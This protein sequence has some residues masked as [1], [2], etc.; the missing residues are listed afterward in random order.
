[1]QTK[2]PDRTF[3]RVLLEPKVRVLT[4]VL[5]GIVTLSSSLA[6]APP[7][8]TQGPWR[9]GV[10]R[11]TAVFT[12]V[13]DGP[14]TSQIK[15][16]IDS[17]TLNNVQADAGI[18]TT[19]HSW[20]ASGLPGGTQIYYQVCSANTAG[21]T[22][23]TVDSFSTPLQTAIPAA[24]A[25]PKPVDSPVIPTG[26]ILTVGA[27][28]DDP[29][30]GLV[31]MWNRA[32]WGD[33]VEIDPAVTPV[34]AG[35]YVFPAK[36]PDTAPNRYIL[37]RVRNAAGLGQGRVS[38]LNRLRM[39]RFIDTAPNVI[40]I[41]SADPANLSCFAGSYLWRQRQAN[42]WAM[43]RCNNQPPQNITQIP[44][45][46][47]LNVTVPNHGIQDGRMVWVSNATGAGAA[48]VNGSWLTQV[49]DPNTILLKAYIGAAPQT[50]TGPA[51]G[52]TMSLNQ[53]Q[54]E[55]VIEGSDLPAACD[56][57]QWWHK[58]A[59]SGSEDEYHRTYYCSADNQWLPYRMDPNSGAT[60][61]PVIDLVTNQAHN[62]IFQGLSFEP[63]PLK[64]DMQRL[65]YTYQPANQESGTLFWSF[66]SQSRKNHHIYWDQILADCP[67]P[68]PNGSMVRCH[69]F[70]NP[71]DGAHI[72]VRRSYFRG[73]QI[74][75][76]A[77][78]LD[79]GSAIVFSVQHGP[80]PHEFV[81]NHIECTGICVYY[82]DDTASTSDASDLTFTQNDVAT[83]DRYWDRSP[84]WL[85]K[86]SFTQ[87]IF[88]SQRHRFEL[89]RLKRGIL[90]GNTFTGG[91]AWINNAAAICLC[92]RG[93]ASG[94]QISS[95][96]DST[97]VTYDAS[98]LYDWGIEDLHVGD[99]VVLQN[100][101]GGTCASTPQVF[102]VASVVNS[103]TFTVS[104]PPGCT[105][106]RGNVA[107][108]G[109]ET[110]YI[111]DIAI[112]NNTIKDS[113][114]GVY[115]LGHDSYAGPPNGLISDAMQRVRIVNNLA[116]RLDGTRVGM[117]QFSA[118]PEVA[119]TGTFVVPIYAMED[120]EVSHN[121][122]YPRTT[123]AFMNSDSGV[124]GP[125]SGLTLKANI[126]EYLAGSGLVNDGSFF[127]VT[128][129][130]KAW[131]SGTLP[132]FTAPYN[133]ILR[134]GGAVGSPADPT[135][136]PFGPYPASTYWLDTNRT[137]VPF[138]N[139][140]SGDYSLT[141][142]YRHADACNG[143]PGDCTDDGTDVGVNMTTLLAAQPKP[144][145]LLH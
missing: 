45:N 59:S 145:T 111:S 11:S 123:G 131:L 53:F 16:G 19:I 136:P 94:S 142:L 43:Y 91:W 100:L 75:H 87:N 124:G 105:A 95:V 82:T 83:P 97:I 5:V 134:P 49:V 74:F 2:S 118:H 9:T 85:G 103:F 112:T 40:M 8:I 12:W 102:S 121:T 52:G 68:D 58:Q 50:S 140:A 80:G 88:W 65:Q 107:R 15:W 36:A 41:G 69:A 10:T 73:W 139:P 109:N 84:E 132:Q 104:P 108:L 115:M 86:T 32:N 17:S 21:A 98:T 7:N 6:A 54:L 44:D 57:G 61:A 127:G 130:T 76:S 72:S 114:T 56:Y 60:P 64:A 1:M 138:K 55:P 37:T 117:G 3:V 22:C 46:G 28:C 110:A 92:T 128:G 71:L 62:L 4:I 99:R 81:N 30:T 38:S 135:Q 13:T 79:D 122:V 51:S 141:G 34:C 18:P 120:L 77:Q 27:N 14:S 89:K 66:V 129:L 39:A 63:L 24:P 78:D 101:A 90:D 137:P 20:Y 35:S 23:S 106:T 47:P 26:N 29:A 96:S 113:P 48:A 126:F 125:S 42:A 25:P 67:D 93:G 70:A 33:I 31:A 133:L 144:S 119:P 116:I 143:T